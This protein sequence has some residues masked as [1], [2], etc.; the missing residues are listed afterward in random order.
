MKLILNLEATWSYKF[1]GTHLR[2]RKSSLPTF[3]SDSR[4]KK[5]RGK[6]NQKVVPQRIKE[7]EQ[8]KQI[9]IRQLG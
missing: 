6:E 7:Q 4:S 1:T 2:Q 5:E 3:Q 9:D 8:L